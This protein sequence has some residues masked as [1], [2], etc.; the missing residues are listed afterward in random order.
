[1]TK[2]TVTLIVV[3]VLMAGAYVYWFTDW[4]QPA[5][6]QI[7]AQV[8]PSRAVQPGAPGYVATYPVSF[9][10]DRKLRLT[11]LK[12]LSVD[13]ETT[14]K[15]PHPVWHMIS[16]SN[17]IPT[18]AIIYG[19]WLRGMKPKV[20]HARP[21][22]LLPDVKY[23]LYVGAGKLKGQIDFKTVEVPGQ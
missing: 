19:Q 7:L 14:N 3:L 2:S 17:S 23:R 15:Y 18:K 11:E 8:R 10:F 1:M 22:P 5:T 13:D 16:D 12:V 6:I 20:P 9:A 21:E 4:F